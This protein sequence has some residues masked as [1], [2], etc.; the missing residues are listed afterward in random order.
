M[1]RISMFTRRHKSGNQ[2]TFHSRP[3]VRGGG[4]ALIALAL[5]VIFIF[6]SAF[7]FWQL[8]QLTHR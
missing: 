7:A 4:G 1:R 2:I 3:Y 5:V 6:S 8:Y